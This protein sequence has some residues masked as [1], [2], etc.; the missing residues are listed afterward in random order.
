[1]EI[2]HL[3]HHLENALA[4]RLDVAL[5]PQFVD[6]D[7][8]REFL[9]PDAW[10]RSISKGEVGIDRLGDR[11]LQGSRND[12]PLDGL[13]PYHDQAQPTSAGPSGSGDW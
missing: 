7:F 13:A 3:G 4:D 11:S 1:M 8:R 12:A 10:S 6:F 2:A 9:A 5:D